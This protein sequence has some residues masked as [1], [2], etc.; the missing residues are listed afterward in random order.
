[1]IEVL[2]I[3]NAAKLVPIEDDATPADPVQENQTSLPANQSK[4]FIEQ[5]HEAHIR[6]HMAAYSETRR[7]SS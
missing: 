3:K 4:A 1:M 2:G 7:F 5:N 6:V